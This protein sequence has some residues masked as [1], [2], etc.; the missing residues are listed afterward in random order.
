MSLLWTRKID[1]E[2]M[3]SVRTR[4]KSAVSA[5]TVKVVRWL[6]LQRVT[7][8]SSGEASMR[9]PWLLHC[10]VALSQKAH[11]SKTGH[12]QLLMPPWL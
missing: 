12:W 7:E 3:Y 5:S 10:R 6:Q 2:K 9:H 4:M 11:R 8:D 1:V